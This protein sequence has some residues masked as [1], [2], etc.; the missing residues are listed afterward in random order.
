MMKNEHTA[1]LNAYKQEIPCF[2]L[3]GDAVHLCG[4]VITPWPREHG[5]TTTKDTIYLDPPNTTFCAGFS[6]A[7]PLDTEGLPMA[8]EGER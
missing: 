4:V 2:R 5:R 1:K 3:C 6:I 8:C 7:V